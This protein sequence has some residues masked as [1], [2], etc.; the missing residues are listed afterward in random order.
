[1][2]WSIFVYGTLRTGEPNHDLLAHLTPQ[3]LAHTEPLYELINLGAFPAMVKGG[4]TSVVGEVYE[5]D[6]ATL[7]ALDHLEGH[8]RFYR[9]CSIKLR[10][11]AEVEAY[12]L[13]THQA[14]G[15]DRISGG[16][17]VKR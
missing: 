8:P 1:M 13:P 12:L 11:G 9:R 5:V 17:W 7:Q 16:D 4:T 2:I 6:Y 10:E 3:C 14:Q 15:Y